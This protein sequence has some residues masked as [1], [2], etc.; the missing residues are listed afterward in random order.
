M[1]LGKLTPLWQLFS[2]KWVSGF[3]KP[4]QDAMSMGIHSLWTTSNSL[5]PTPEV[6]HTAY[7]EF[8]FFTGMRPDEI[9]A[10]RW[11]DVDF[12]SGYARGS[13]KTNP[14]AA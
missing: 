12:R 5:C 6:I 7:F 14:R 11:N 2:P 8:A 4:L 1:L 3:T 9:L 10:L 13:R